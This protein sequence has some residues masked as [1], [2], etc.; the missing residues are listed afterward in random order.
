M[1]EIITK[2][3]VLDDATSIDIYRQVKSAALILNNLGDTIE[4]WYMDEQSEEMKNL[5]LILNSMYDLFTKKGTNMN[6]IPGIEPVRT[7]NNKEYEE[8]LL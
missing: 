5:V 7:K 3:Q 4:L 6:G 8:D 2:I 1:G